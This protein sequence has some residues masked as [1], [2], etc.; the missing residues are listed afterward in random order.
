[1]TATFCD[2]PD[3]AFRGFSQIDWMEITLGL[4][5]MPV[6]GDANCDRGLTAADL[7]AVI[8]L[9]ATG[10]RS[11]CELDDTDGDGVIDGRDLDNVIAAIFA[12][13]A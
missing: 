3:T 11:I 6:I 7:A 1:M 12:G 4:L 9:I 2:D 8:P 10:E 5:D 13:G